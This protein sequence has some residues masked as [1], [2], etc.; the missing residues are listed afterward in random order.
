MTTKD[1]CWKGRK[2]L[3]QEISRT[4]SHIVKQCTECKGKKWSH[5]RVAD[6]RTATAMVY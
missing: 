3:Y 5:R 6:S 1:T 2:H 4:K